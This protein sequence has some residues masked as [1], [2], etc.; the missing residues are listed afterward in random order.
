MEIFRGDDVDIAVK[1][2][3]PPDPPANP[4]GKPMNLSGCTLWF[5][6]KSA[7]DDAPNDDAA[8]VKL[9]WVDGGASNGIEV[10]D[11]PNGL[12]MLTVPG[13]AALQENTTYRCDVQVL[14]AVGKKRTLVV[15]ELSIKPDVT[16]RTTT[17]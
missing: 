15:D 14:T 9:F 11:K 10:T 12:V 16:K 6:V 1:C 17:P 3:E 8:L 13:S 2:L 4:R 5:T 7:D